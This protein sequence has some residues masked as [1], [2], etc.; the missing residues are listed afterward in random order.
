MSVNVR[1]RV[2]MCKPTQ[3]I[4]VVALCL[5]WAYLFV[6]LATESADPTYAIL[7]NPTGAQSRFLMLRREQ[8]LFRATAADIL[9]DVRTP[10]VISSAPHRTCAPAPALRCLIV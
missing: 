7:D 4:V 10:P 3:V 1:A 6:L 8:R 5:W 2:C 9:I